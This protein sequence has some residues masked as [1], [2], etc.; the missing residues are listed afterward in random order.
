MSKLNKTISKIQ[1]IDKES[2]EKTQKRLDNLTKPA[3]SLGR[4][5]DLVKQIV[6]ITR[7]DK[8]TL[9]RKVIFTLAGDHGISEENIS[10]FPKE[11]TAQMIYNFLS[12]GA[13]INVL[14]NHTGCEVIV[15]DMGVAEK[16]KE[17]KIENKK[18]KFIDKKINFG[19]KNFL[20]ETAM[21][22]S[23]AIKSIEIG[24]ELVENE[25]NEGLDIIGCG[26]M[27]IG[28]TTSSSII[29]ALICGKEAEEVT[30]KGTGIKEEYYKK[31]IEIV[32][33]AVTIH[34]PT[35]SSPIDILAKVGGYE[36][37]GIAGIILGGAANK[38]P[39]VLD[40]FITGASA[41]IAYKL[42]PLIKD[43]I[44]A[45]HSSAEPGHKIILDYLGLKPLLNLNLRLGEGT[46]AALGISLAE[47]SCKIL[48]EMATFKDAGVSEEKNN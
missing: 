42:N 14:A 47:A 37:G 13:G 8:L 43:Y 24:I 5:E 17:Q 9:K 33:K 41:L 26:D 3:G 1:E 44:I 45:S 6:A 4:L 19:T 18:C 12:G 39:I 30:G 20:K 27:G 29:T 10:A 46:G 35:I 11:V 34:K 16:I 22:K 15:I 2:F 38:K 25:L 48:N 40:G 36:I 21:T 32:K 23:E 28:N 7:N 31:K